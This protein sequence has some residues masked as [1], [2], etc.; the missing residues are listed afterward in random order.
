MKHFI[1]RDPA[2]V[3]V[4]VPA[5]PVN[6]VDQL[7]KVDLSHLK[8]DQRLQLMTLLERYCRIFDPDPGFTKVVQ[9]KIAL[10]AYAKA[11]RQTP[12][13]LSPNITRWVNSQLPSLVDYDVIAVLVDP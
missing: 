12:Y 8:L 6:P 10:V 1:A 2:L 7:A 3:A 4:V 5:L 9:H 13:R 11:S